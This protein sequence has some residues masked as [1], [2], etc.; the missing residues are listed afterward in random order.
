M[1]HVTLVGCGNIGFRHLQALGAMSVAPQVALTVVEPFAGHHDRI[2]SELDRAMFGQHDL[3][4]ALP[5]ARK[6][7]D[8]AVLA[9]NADVRRTVTDALL[10]T[11]NVA[12]IIFEKILF[13]RIADIDAVE[14]RLDRIRAHV[15]CGRR[16][17]PG[18]HA[19]RR[20]IA[21]QGPANVTVTG[22]NYALASNAIHLIDIAAYLNDSPVVSIDSHDLDP[23][24]ES[25]KRAGYV[26]VFGTLHATLA[27]GAK[28]ALTCLRGDG[29]LLDITVA[30]PTQTWR[31]NE[32]G[33]TITDETAS[34][35]R[36]FETR[37]VSGM[38]ELYESLLTDQPCPLTPY[39]EAADQHRLL[40]RAL[41]VHLQRG[42]D[43]DTLCP[44]S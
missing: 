5:A 29:L 37:H 16:G 12:A 43:P 20:D 40:L 21:G 19:L 31:I 26:E 39:A 22:T 42:D 17:F 1:K 38:P 9:T 35:P 24:I 14:A 33:G 44:I 30:T 6:D 3:V 15:N 11:H 41:N 8:L 18:Y 7:I 4:T 32:L 28:V 34:A 2:A 10:D 27:N 23:K 13:Q 25:S 36:P